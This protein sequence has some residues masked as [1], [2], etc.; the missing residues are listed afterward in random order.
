MPNGSSVH[1]DCLARLG[2]HVNTDNSVRSAVRD[3][4]DQLGA[5]FT[6]GEIWRPLGIRR[7]NVNRELA[8]MLKKGLLTRYKVPVQGRNPGTG[9]L[10]TRQVYLYSLAKGYE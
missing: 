5:P 3:Y 8:R 10:E 2:E 6:I 9:L 7:E 4:I 1:K